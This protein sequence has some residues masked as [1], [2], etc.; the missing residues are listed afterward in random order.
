MPLDDLVGVIKTLRQRINTHRKFLEANETRTRMALIDPLLD[1]LGWDPSNP[2]SVRPEL[3]ISGTRID[4]ALQDG[5]G[6]SIVF[7]EA[8]ELGEPLEAHTGEMVLN[9]NMAGVEYAG[10]TNGNRWEFYD[11]FTAK[12]LAE[13]QILSIS[14]EEDDPAHSALQLLWLW[15]PNLHAGATDS[16]PVHAKEPLVHYQ[17][18]ANLKPEDWT[19][20]EK[21]NAD[22]NPPVSIMFP[23]G[24]TY[25]TGKTWKSLLVKAVT[26]LLE[27]S[28]ITPAD[29][30][31]YNTEDRGQGTLRLLQD[32]PPGTEGTRRRRWTEI[33][34]HWLHTDLT[35]ADVCRHTTYLVKQFGGGQTLYVRGRDNPSRVNNGG[36]N[37]VVPPNE[38]TP[39]EGWTPIENFKVNP[40]DPSPGYI[41][42]SDGQ[43]YPI[44]KTW[45]S[46]LVKAVT[47]LLDNSRITPEDLPIYTEGKGLL[48]C[49][50]F[51]P[52]SEYIRRTRWTEIQGYWLMTGLSSADICRHITY[53]V[54]QFGGGQTLYI[55][56]R[57]PPTDVMR[58]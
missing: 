16:P 49:E 29:L 32:L 9:A 37:P 41:R 54:K 34:G 47:L 7:I 12:P 13:R 8:K 31:I 40:G 20:I 33:Q 23:G 5:E 2:S 18:R 22:D 17:K 58:T 57:Q 27:N 42:Y 11:V 50:T 38:R 4:Y 26:L 21:I 44:D 39:I 30:P 25:Q 51:P 28:C 55:C 10:L 3:A 1:I 19:P 53:L 48:L 52:V 46:L 43:A 15:R 35:A 36:P 45:K 56:D 14:L 6:N 24:Q